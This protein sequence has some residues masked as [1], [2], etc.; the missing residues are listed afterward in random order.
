[1]RVSEGRACHS[2][3]SGAHNPLIIINTSLRAPAGPRPP[4]PSLNPASLAA[5]REGIPFGHNKIRELPSGA[6]IATPQTPWSPCPGVWIEQLFFFYTF[7]F[8]CGKRREKVRP[9]EAVRGV[10]R[11]VCGL[12]WRPYF[13]CRRET[14]LKRRSPPL[15]T[16]LTGLPGRTL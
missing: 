5:W 14:T 4:L 7:S 6:S 2:Q 15:P 13:M 12:D 16:P 10:G 11:D 3:R 8:W 9:D 1:V